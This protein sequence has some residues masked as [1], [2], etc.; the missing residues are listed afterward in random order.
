MLGST[1]FCAKLVESEMVEIRIKKK[2]TRMEYSALNND[3]LAVRR[4]IGDETGYNCARKYGKWSAQMAFPATSLS[5][6]PADDE[7]VHPRTPTLKPGTANAPALIDLRQW[8]AALEPSALQI[9]SM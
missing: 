9:C 6:D 4:T 8:S 1:S 5:L 7:S 3:P 2:K